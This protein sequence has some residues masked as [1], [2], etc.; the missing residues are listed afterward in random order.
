MDDATAVALVYTVLFLLMVETVYLVMLIAPRRPT[1]YKLMRYEA[2]NPESGPAKAPLAMQYLGYV[3]MLVT[4][5]P[6]VAIPLA[7]HIMFNNLQLTVI[8]ALIGGVVAVAASAYGY[9]YAKRIELWRVT[10]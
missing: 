2:G 4:L 9:R 8:T 6:A 5:E 10:S 1:P 7:V 3:L